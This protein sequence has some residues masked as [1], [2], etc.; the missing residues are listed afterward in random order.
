MIVPVILSG[1]V[2][3]RLWPLSREHLPKQLMPIMGGEYSLFQKTLMRL[4]DIPLAEHPLIV[5]N[6]SHRFMAA[7][8]MQA[9]NM[10]HSGII[11]EPVGRNTCPAIT[12]AAIAALRN[13]ED[14]NLLV[15]PADHLI[16]DTK[17]FASAVQM[18]NDLASSGNIITFGIVPD[19][20]ET[21]YGYIKMGNRISGADS[22]GDAYLVS[23]FA[24]KPEYEIACSYVDSKEFLW[25]SGMFMFRASAYL[26]E[27]EQFAPEILKACSESYE[28]AQQDLDFIRLG[29][30]A[31]TACPSIS[32]D[33]AVMEKTPRAVVIP[34]EVGWSDVGSWLSLHE[35]CGKDECHNVI[36]GDVVLEDVRNCY[37]HSENRLVAAL[38]VENQIIIETKDAVLVSSID[39]SQDVKLIVSRLKKEMREEA[40]SHS[41]TYRP[42]GS[43]ELI[44]N[45]DRFK[46]KRITVNPGASL[47]RQMHYHRAEHWI[48]VRGTAR[49]TRGEEVFLLNEDQST[50]IPWGTQHRLENPGK[51]PLELIEVQS[52]S[53]LGEDD[54]QRFD[55]VY[56]RC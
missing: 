20:P 49:I 23:E 50:Y 56:G 55:D 42:W 3:S 46:V 7:A 31:F 11:L 8:Q 5:C 47:S 33:Y 41:R 48:V 40:L 53:Y 34:L 1:G 44:D 22:N 17:L 4:W 26:H 25:N 6:E 52:G 21:G 10:E 13:G 38:G 2:G 36:T 43:Y 9:I 35:V 19:R 39:R 28:N 54:I 32:I 18:G 37:I 27:L 24:E 29:E 45:G 12:V 51:I 30:S 16:Q 15:L 14:P